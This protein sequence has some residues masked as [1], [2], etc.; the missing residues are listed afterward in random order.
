LAE[1]EFLAVAEEALQR[2]HDPEVLDALGRAIA[3]FDRALRLQ[4]SLRG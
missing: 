3:E 2:P 1:D 4:R